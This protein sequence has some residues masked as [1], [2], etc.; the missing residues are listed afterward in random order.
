M[1]VQI[2]V[3][4][5]LLKNSI[6]IMAMSVQTVMVFLKMGNAPIVDMI[7]VLILINKKKL[8]DLISNSV[9]L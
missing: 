3:V 8:R 6:L 2:V 5:W 4:Q 9:L 7:L 1:S